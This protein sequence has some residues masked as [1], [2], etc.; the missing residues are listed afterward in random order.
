MT[1]ASA[2]VGQ[3]SIRAKRNGGGLAPD[4]LETLPPHRTALAAYFKRPE[5]SK[6]HQS[7]SAMFSGPV[8]AES[9]CCDLA[10]AL[11][12]AHGTVVDNGTATS[13]RHTMTTQSIAP[14]RPAPR[15]PGPARHRRIR[16]AAAITGVAALI[17]TGGYVAGTTNGTDATPP[18]PA[19][20]TDVNPSAQ[21]L[22]DMH[23]SIAGQYGSRS[24]PNAVDPSAQVRREMRESVAGQYSPA[25]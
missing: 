19:A 17:A 13:R 7:V 24:A 15:A 9:G 3:A 23:R 12:A 21:A 6:V 16:T 8:R 11:Q 14:I 20:G 2:Q 22:R 25:R 10:S 18:T 4:R 1:R 5:Y